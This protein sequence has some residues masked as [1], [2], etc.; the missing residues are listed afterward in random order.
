V[1]GI[2][3]SKD[4]KYATLYWCLPPPSISL[5]GFPESFL[6]DLSSLATFSFVRLLLGS[7]PLTG[8]VSFFPR[9]RFAF[10]LRFEFLAPV[11]I[12]QRPEKTLW[13]WRR[14][15]SAIS[16]WPSSQSRRSATMVSSLPLVVINVFLFRPFCTIVDVVSDSLPSSSRD[17]EVIIVNWLDGSC[18]VEIS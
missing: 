13:E 12:S 5:I 9:N 10:C 16:T 6:V 7:W 1:G 15:G 3:L 11:G 2:T 8:E 4:L 17:L 14:R 18:R